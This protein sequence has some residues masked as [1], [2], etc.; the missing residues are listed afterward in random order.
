MT[1]SILIV[2]DDLVL[3]EM[4][5][6]YLKRDGHQAA[7]AA[8]LTEGIEQARNDAFDIIFLD[9]RLPDGNGLE[10]FPHF[11][12]V[13]S[14]PEIIIMTGSGDRDGAK[15]AIQSG[16]WSYLEKPHILRDLML[17]LTRAL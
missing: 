10:A 12:E 1:A 2:D 17:P 16:A 14:R 11:S 5:A 7:I 3:A 9:V 6:G 15:K 13:I 4:L 8:T